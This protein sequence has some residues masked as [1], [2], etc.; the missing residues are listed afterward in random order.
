[1]AN[2]N[3][4]TVFSVILFIAFAITVSIVITWSR[5]SEAWRNEAVNTGHAEYYLDSDRDRQ[6]RWKPVV[7][8]IAK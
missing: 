1:M 5:V 3:H 2:D 7:K 6:W 8:E 4:E